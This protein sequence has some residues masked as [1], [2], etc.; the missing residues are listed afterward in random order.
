MLIVILSLTVCITA[1]I[2]LLKAK[3][4]LFMFQICPMKQL[5]FCPEVVFK[6]IADISLKGGLN[7]W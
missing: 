5:F 7:I 2:I 1:V 6:A 3:P 4:D